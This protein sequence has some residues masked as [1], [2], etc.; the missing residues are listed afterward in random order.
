MFVLIFLFAATLNLFVLDLSSVHSCLRNYGSLRA[1]ENRL[2]IFVESSITYSCIAR[3]GWT[4]VGW[5][6]MS[7]AIKTD[8]DQ[9]DG[10]PRVAMHRKSPSLFIDIYFFDDLLCWFVHLADA[11]TSLMTRLS[12]RCCSGGC[13]ARMHSCSE[14]QSR[15][16]IRTEQFTRLA[17]RH[18]GSAV[19][20][21]RRTRTASRR[22][23]RRLRR[24][25][26][27]GR[28]QREAGVVSRVPARQWR[29]RA[30]TTQCV[31]LCRRSAARAGR[32]PVCRSRD[33]TGHFRRPD[34]CSEVVGGTTCNVSRSFWRWAHANIS[35]MVFSQIST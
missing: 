34:D 23:G 20:R 32:L 30:R 5:C 31:S 29:S 14:Q 13:W 7:L 24:W 6:I 2:E 1:A 27:S 17:V 15:S 12:W 26:G 22:V 28:R 4:L 18:A 25:R 21:R 10:Q 11:V 8:N 19:A 16:N 35:N 33:W 9:Q 3:I